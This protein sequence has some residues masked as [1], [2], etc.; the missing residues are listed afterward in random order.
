MPIISLGIWVFLLFLPRFDSK[1]QNSEATL[2]TYRR[3][4]NGIIAILA[5]VHVFILTS[6]DDSEAGFRAIFFML[7]IFLLFLALALPKIQPSGL[8]G[9]RTPWT[10]KDEIIWYKT[11]Q[12]AGFALLDV[13]ILN[14]ILIWILDTEV[15]FIIFMLTIIAVFIGT[16]FYSYWLWRGKDSQSA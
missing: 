14:A 10:L 16:S 15:A 6:Y 11:H 5:G 7:S 13:S 3:M 1:L 4:T 8:V 2:L 12:V 9:I